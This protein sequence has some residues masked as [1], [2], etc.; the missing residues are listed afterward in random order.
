[1]IFMAVDKNTWATTKNIADAKIF[2]D[3]CMN[4]RNAKMYE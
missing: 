3:G 2:P 4:L 1:M